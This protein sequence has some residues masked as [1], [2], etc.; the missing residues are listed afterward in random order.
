MD[1]RLRLKSLELPTRWQTPAKHVTRAGFSTVRRWVL[2]HWEWW[3][4]GAVLLIAALA[5]GINMFH[6]PYFEDDEGTYMAQAWAILHQGQLAPYTY[7]YDHA[8]AGWIQI[9]AWEL[10]TGGNATFGGAIQSGRVLMLLFH[11]GSVYLV[12]RIGRDVSGKPLTGLIAALLFTLSPNEIYFGRR[13]LLD[14]IC[15]FWLLLSVTVL[16]PG[17]LTLTRVWT[18]ALAFAISVLSKELTVF[19][20]PVLAYLIYWRAGQQ[21][22]LMAFANWLTIVCSVCS[23]YVLMAAIKGEVFPTGTLFGGP[24]P[25]VSLLGSLAWQSSRGK[26]GGVF[27]SN[28]GFWNWAHT[29]ILDDP[30]LVV[31]GTLSMIATLFTSKNRRLQGVLAAI[32]L[33][34]WIFLARGGEVID[35]YLIPLLPLLALALAMNVDAVEILLQRAAHFIGTHMGQRASVALSLLVLCGGLFGTALGNKASADLG[36]HTMY[37]KIFWTGTQADAQVEASTW[38]TQHV[39]SHDTVVIDMSMWPDL[40]ESRNNTLVYERADYYWK[41]EQ[42]PAIRQAVY[43]GNWRDINYVVTTTQMLTDIRLNHMTIISDALAHC[44]V[45]AKFDTG[46]WPVNVCKVNHG[47][48]SA[49]GLPSAGATSS[50][51]VGEVRRWDRAS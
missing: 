3:L 18:S 40:H 21:Q 41:V 13:V 29:W 42:D 46:G 45:V 30:I 9:A 22:R 5:H 34:L 15:S 50:A 14:N 8:P 20:L 47:G 48:G 36:L 31:G 17:R 25:H 27:Q 11:L 7:F 44:T 6:Y 49:S 35:F 10:L 23:L 26:D 39:P 38:I 1:Y 4:I 12:Y 43:G 28:S 32:P 2:S 33:A 51:A 16:I 24:R 37:P 19:T